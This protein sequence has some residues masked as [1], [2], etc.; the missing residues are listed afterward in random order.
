VRPVIGDIRVC[1]VSV[2]KIASQTSM[3]RSSAPVIRTNGWAIAFLGL[4]R[5][6]VIDHADSISFS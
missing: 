5:G 4:W 2:T 6:M 1:P 3:I